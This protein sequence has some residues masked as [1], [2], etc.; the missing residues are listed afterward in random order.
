MTNG[1]DRDVIW[2]SLTCDIMRVN[3]ERE[4][5]RGKPSETSTKKAETGECST[6]KGK[7][8]DSSNIGDIFTI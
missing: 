1:D 5:D 8:L 7:A 6:I 3:S 2:V 4:V